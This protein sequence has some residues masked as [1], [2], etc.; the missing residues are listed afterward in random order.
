MEI[1]NT[2]FRK[3]ESI[4][5]ISMAMAK[6]QAQMGKLIKNSKNPFFKNDYAD[7]AAVI[8]ACKE[9]LNSHDI[10]VIQS[11][12]G[13][14]GYVGV[15]T[16]LAHKSGEWIEGTLM[17]SPVKKDPQGAGSCITYARRYSLAAMVGLAQ[18]DDDAEGSIS[19]KS[20]TNSIA[21]KKKEILRIASKCSDLQSLT[22]AYNAIDDDEKE[23]YTEYFGKLRNNLT[24]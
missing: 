15:T 14:N 16:L 19:R 21:D 3:S 24:R 5:I 8:D 17:L 18:E 4:A 23:G 7:L 10:A 12:C 20:T 1:I 6:S 11:P 9:S 13:E 2:A 22:N